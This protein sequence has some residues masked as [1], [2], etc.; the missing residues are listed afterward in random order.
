MGKAPELATYA[1]GMH[2]ELGDAASHSLYIAAQRTWKQCCNRLGE[3]IIPHNNFSGVRYMALGILSA[4]AVLGLGFDGVSTKI[5]MAD[6][7]THV[8]LC[9]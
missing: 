3:V 4:A 1:A 8:D 7:L 5:E 2:L 6:W 9:V